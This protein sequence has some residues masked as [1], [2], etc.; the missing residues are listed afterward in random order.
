MTAI[1]SWAI[2]ICIAA[3]ICGVLELLSPSSRMNGILRF[4]FGGFMLCA[5]IIPLSEIDLDLST[6]PPIEDMGSSTAEAANEQSVEYLKKSIADLVEKKL[7]EI[8]AEAEEISVD[9]DIDGDNCINM[10]TVRLKISAKDLHL[11]N[12]IESKINDELGLKCLINE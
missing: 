1:S 7:A 12:K 3:V 6:I 2:V 4:V 10:I 5:I 8:P 11:S 9:M